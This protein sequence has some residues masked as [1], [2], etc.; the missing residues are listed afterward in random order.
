MCIYSLHKLRGPPQQARA[1]LHLHTHK[2]TCH[3]PLCP[4]TISP[5]LA[6]YLSLSPRKV[7]SLP[8][9][10]LTAIGAGIEV[11]FTDFLRELIWDYV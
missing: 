3:T 5:V 11:R 9:P 4:G 2:H 6:S 10:C 8:F 7:S 1:D